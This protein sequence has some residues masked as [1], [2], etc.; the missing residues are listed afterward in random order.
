MSWNQN[1]GHLF[2]GDV[3]QK[4]GEQFWVTTKRW[5]KKNGSRNGAEAD[6]FEM[7]IL[8]VQACGH[9]PLIATKKKKKWVFC[10]ICALFLDFSTRLK[11]LS[12]AKF[13]EERRTS[14]VIDIGKSENHEALIKSIMVKN[15]QSQKLVVE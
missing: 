3:F 4:A 6:I 8:G 10:D 1:F 9:S 14:K 15:G 7:N 5:R 13:T 2:V 11:I 12:D